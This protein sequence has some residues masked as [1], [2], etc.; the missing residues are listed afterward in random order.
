MAGI[1]YTRRDRVV[2]VYRGADHRIVVELHDGERTRVRVVPVAKGERAS[3]T[4]SATEL[5]ALLFGTSAIRAE[6]ARWKSEHRTSLSAPPSSGEAEEHRLDRVCLRIDDERL[7]G[8]PVEQA[9]QH[10]L[11]D[12]RVGGSPIPRLI[13]LPARVAQVPFTLP[14]RLLQLDRRSDFHLGQ[15]VKSVFRS[16]LHKRGFSSVMQV[17]V[18]SSDA[19]SGWALPSGWRTVDILH[20]DGPA[21]QGK[22]LLAMSTPEQVGTLGWLVRCVDLW[23]T[24][25]VVIRRDVD[26]DMRVL[27]RF[28]HRLAAQGGPAVWLV[29]AAAPGLPARLR[30]FYNKLVH[31]TPIDLAVAIAARSKP[32]A[33]GD[34]LIVGSG[35]EELVRVS[36][37]GDRI[38][39]LAS[40]LSDRDPAVRAESA[41]RL[42]SSIAET[43]LRLD[44]ATASFMTAVRG[45]TGIARRLPGLR[46]DMHEGDGMV[47]LGRSIGTLRR[48]LSIA[49]RPARDIRMVPDR[50]GPRFV[51]PSLWRLDPVTGD[52]EPIP[53][54]AHLQR[55]RPILFGVQLG[56][57]DSYAPVLDAVAIVEE[58]FKWSKGHDGVW[59]SVGVT[60]LD[61]TVVGAAIQQVWLPRHG[62]SDLVEFL[63]EPTQ[64][65]ISQLRFCIY[66][67]AD[68]LQSHRLAALVVEGPPQAGPSTGADL[69]LAK[70]LG[71][72]IERVGDAGWLARMEYAAAADLAAPPRNRDV[73]LSLFANKHDGRRVFTARGTEGFEILEARDISQHVEDVRKELEAIS[74]DK[75]N[76][77]AFRERADK[78]RHVGTPDQRDRALLSLAR[79]GRI[80][81]DAILKEADQVTLA[82]DLAGEQRVIH[83]AHS[84][85]ED[86]IPWAAI[87]DRPYDANREADDDDLPVLHAVCPAG[88]PDA[89]GQFAEA[90][91]EKHANCLLSPERKKAAAAAGQGV[92][93]DTIVCARHF[94]GFRHIIEIPP[95]QQDGSAVPAAAAPAVPA[96]PATRWST[97]SA[98]RPA[99]LLLGYNGALATIDTHRAE[100]GAMIQEIKTSAVWSETKRRDALLKLLRQGH[101]DLVYLFCHARGGDADPKVRPPA[102]EFQETEA[103]PPA[104]IN[105][106][107]F[108][109]VKLRNHPLVFL[110]GCNTAAF[111]PDALS[112]FIRKLILDCDVA[113]VIGTEIPVFELLAGEMARLFLKRFLAGG[114]D[115]KAGKAL[116]GSRLDLLARGNPLGLVYTLYALAELALVQKA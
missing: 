74:R 95:Y 37:P 13:P 71:V 116:L 16:H 70:A 48:S 2:R 58:P 27:R 67:D 4:E 32:N 91:C 6:L 85:L 109:G 26:T 21:I 54:S 79:V 64:C 82:A 113:G 75:F 63:V 19:F 30:M 78:P 10:A 29:D 5:A 25:L 14:L 59:L 73:A 94:W 87:Y 12:K 35:R 102:L 39:G 61:F 88:L 101:A 53:Q 114:E 68:L 83:V 97:T 49:A 28:A 93:D 23:R 77:Y 111:S 50:S 60:G 65:G 105:A 18:A 20:L 55:G 108:R 107:D 3:K 11:G 38:A 31:D 34:T 9:L 66:F 81:F 7:A 84:L 17:E 40:G 72:P 86:V 42:W 103:S 98:A 57:R 24:R 22:D 41:G 47:P 106:A 112:P 80:L 62:A 76:L 51:N 33:A 15:T 43:G 110:N 115:G 89:K 99:N 52:K 45:L 46:F 36:G 1:R 8:L 100:L 56:P 69:S 90:A 96:I 104:L 44:E 92:A